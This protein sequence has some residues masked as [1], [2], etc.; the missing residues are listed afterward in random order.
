M[1]IGTSSSTASHNLKCT[2]VNNG[3]LSQEVNKGRIS[4]TTLETTARRRNGES[5]TRPSMLST[6]HAPDAAL[7]PAT[8]PPPAKRRRKLTP[9]STVWLLEKTKEKKING[10]NPGL[11]MLTR[12]NQKKEKG[13]LRPLENLQKKSKHPNADEKCVI[14]SL[15]FALSAAGDTAHTQIP[16]AWGATRQSLC[17]CNCEKKARNNNLLVVRKP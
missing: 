12:L 11:Q 4:P 13:W 5:A 6:N 1:I 16:I 10:I 8:T 15:M 14:P 2:G 7:S 3:L 17:N 9:N